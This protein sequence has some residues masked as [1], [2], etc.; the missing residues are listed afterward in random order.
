MAMNLEERKTINRSLLSVGLGVG[1]LG[2][3]LFTGIK[4][5][6]I[7]AAA[8]SDDTPVIVIGGSMTFK[9]GS[10]KS[11]PWTEV[12]AGKE[13]SVS[14]GYPISTIVVKLIGSDDGGNNPDPGDANPNTDKLRVDVSLASSWKIDAY[15]DPSDA[16]SPVVSI[17]PNESGEI[18]LVRLD[19]NALL[20]PNDSKKRVMYGHTPDCKDPITFYRIGLKV[21][22]QPTGTLICIDDAVKTVGKCRIVFRGTPSN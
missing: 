5:L 16:A 17:A 6:L 3:F 20:C 8:N 18:H 1:I 14:P 19:P 10:K 7:R 13:Y 22:G 9:S 2:A 4:A 11:P 15:A 21:N 12:S